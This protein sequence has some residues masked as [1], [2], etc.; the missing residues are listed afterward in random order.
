MK[1][2]KLKVLVIFLVI[3]VVSILIGKIGI[4]QH[5]LSRNKVVIVKDKINSNLEKIIN[6][7]NFRKSTILRARKIF[8]DRK[9]NREI[10]R[11]KQAMK[12]IEVEYQSIRK[13]EIDLATPMSLK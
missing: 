6:E 10:A 12:V 1:K 7:D 13:G 8:N 3:V 9:K 5:L 2:N 4:D 11:N